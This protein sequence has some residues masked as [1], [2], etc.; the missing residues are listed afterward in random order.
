MLFGGS[1]MYFTSILSV[2]DDGTVD[3]NPAEKNFTIERKA[4]RITDA[5][6][7]YEKVEGMSFAERLASLHGVNKLDNPLKLFLTKLAREEKV[8]GSSFAHVD[9]VD[10]DV[11]TIDWPVE[12]KLTNVLDQI[13]NPGWFIF[14]GEVE[15][16][17]ENTKGK[18]GYPVG[19]I[20]V[21]KVTACKQESCEEVRDTV[22]FIRSKYKLPDWQP[23][24]MEGGQ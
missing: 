2:K 10:G 6:V 13:E 4:K 5:Y 7:E 16:K 18:F 11:A 3:I 17:D 21:S 1:S 23:P 24:R 20:D 15:I 8:E 14:T 19:A 9:E 12:M 22:Q